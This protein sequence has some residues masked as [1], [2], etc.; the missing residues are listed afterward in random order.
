MTTASYGLGERQRSAVA[1]YGPVLGLLA[2]G[3]GLAAAE[4]TAGLIRGTESPVIAV[5]EEFIDRSPPWLTEWAKQQFGTADKDV[6]IGGAFVTIVLIGIG[7]GIAAVRGA[8]R[9]AVAAT[10]VTGVIG[11]WA[12]TQR[13]SFSVVADCGRRSPA[14]RRRSA[15]SGGTGGAACASC[16]R[17]SEP[18]MA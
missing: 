16:G 18:P 10:V 7:I 12:V 3:A 13:P 8:W 6:L 5:G 11:A 14:R 17:P 1:V 15:C 4:L 2:T 9:L